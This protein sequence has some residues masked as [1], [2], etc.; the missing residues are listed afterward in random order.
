MIFREKYKTFCKLPGIGTI[1]SIGLKWVPCFLLNWFFD[2]PDRFGPR[3]KIKLCEAL[4]DCADFGSF[5]E[6]VTSCFT[7]Q[8]KSQ[9]YTS[10]FKNQ[11]PQRPLAEEIKKDFENGKGFNFNSRLSLLDLKYW[12]PFSVLFR[13]DKMNMAHAVETRSPFLDYRVVEMA[14]NLPD[15]SKLT[16][17]WSKEV[18][19]SLMKRWYPSELREKG[20]QA[21]Y[22]PMT[23][24]YREKFF[25]WASDLLN[26]K[27]I[28][29]RGLFNVSYVENLFETSKKGSMLANRQLAALAMLEQWFRVMSDPPSSNIKVPD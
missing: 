12:I 14:L 29:S 23:S 8:D 9:L 2:Y 16:R 27:S 24:Q 28:E 7:P 11:I 26:P 18:L 10:T 3:E 22:M 21:F 15:E 19:R 6:A 5:Y 20:K 25:E 4:S 13:L 17:Q 1:L